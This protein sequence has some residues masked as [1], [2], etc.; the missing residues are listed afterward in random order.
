[1]DAGSGA[2]MTGVRVIALY[3]S[4][5]TIRNDSDLHKNAAYFSVRRA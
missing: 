1:M 5:M 2:G 3:W 4:G